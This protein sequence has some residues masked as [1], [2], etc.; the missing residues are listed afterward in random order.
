MAGRAGFIPGVRSSSTSCSRAVIAVLALVLLVA[1][2]PMVEAGSINL[3]WN[4]PTTNA[5]GTPL[6]DL[7]NYRVYLNTA[8][9]A[10]PSSSFLTVSSSTSTPNP[11]Q[12]VN[13]RV[14]ALTAGTTYFARI[15]AV[16]SAGNESGC[17]PSA[18][19][20]AL[21]DFN[22]TP[23]A[24][25]DFGSVTTGGTVDRSFSVLN[26]STTSISGTASVGSPYSIVTGG[27]FTLAAGASQTVT[28]RF[29]PTVAGT[30]AGNV[31]VTAG[32]DTISRALTG[33][34]TSVPMV[35][36]SVTI[37]G[38]GAGTVTSIPAGISCGATC[39]VSV[40]A[41]TQMSVTATAASGST[42]AGWSGACTGTVDACTWTM[43][44]STTMTATF[45]TTR[46]D[47]PLEPAPVPVAS[48]LLPNTATAGSPAMALTVNGSGFVATSV[49][50]WNGSSRTTTVISATQLSAA[51][52]A[53]DLA[54]ARSNSVTVFTPTP[55]GGTSAPLTFTTTAAPLAP[56]A[57]SLSPSTV[58]AGSPA[59]NLTV[60]GQRFVPTS[61]VRWNGSPRSTTYVSATQLRATINTTDLASAGSVPVTVSTPAPGGGVSGAVSFAVNAP[62][63][64][65]TPAPGA[66]P[67][68]PHNVKASLLG[69]DASGATFSV[70]WNAVSAATSYR[71]IAGFA[72]GSAMQ[73]G[74]VAGLVTFQLRMPYHQNG[75]A[76]GGFVCVRSVNA[77]GQSTDQACAGLSVPAPSAGSP[78]PVAS[79][80][81]PASAVAGSPAFTLTVNGSGFATS[82]VVRW[83]GVAR[84]TTFVSA[85]QLRATIAATDIASAGSVPV[86]VS[87]PAPG[88]GVSGVVS[89][90]VN[91]PAPSPAPVP[92]TPGVTPAAPWSPSVTL[93]GTDA[94]GATFS[95]AWNAASGATSYRYAAAFADGSASQQGTVTSTSFQLRMPYHASGASS[96]GF[97]CVRS[98]GATGLQSTDQSCSVVMVPGR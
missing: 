49:I 68:P 90:A 5:D 37:N 21:T 64:A 97:V 17:S 79:S 94:S 89:F 67:T 1:A 88:G 39:S 32:G 73:Q 80:L 91:T 81:S 76:F 30:F 47:R 36:L 19:G 83:N 41:G 14:T 84:T 74:T 72:D 92:P 22:V 52:T 87:T 65:P 85:T 48:S 24:T 50:R 86:S 18:S 58:S 42:F 43:S 98:V 11:G 15:T 61:V 16:D 4:A 28:V 57:R 23:T 6:T 20:V 54:S 59:I 71:Y 95:V 51:L 56:I 60:S 12:T 55:G 25:T 44:A 46:V 63:P 66:L 34:G 93:L 26:T 9:P 13:S 38:T 62:A 7:A 31:N 35:G 53:A 69:T 3:S 45:N 29:R 2:A 82:S 10:C 75:G 77:T 33:V 96:G 70:S 27:S 8:T 78:V 40:P